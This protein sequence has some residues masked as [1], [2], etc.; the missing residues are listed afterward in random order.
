MRNETHRLMHVYVY[1][2]I[3]RVKRETE[4]A[5]FVVSGKYSTMM[6]RSV[7]A[8]IRAE[9]CIF[10]FNK[11]RADGDATG[12][13]PWVGRDGETGRGDRGSPGG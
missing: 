7:K 9:S 1:I 3:L 8:R 2:Y 5:K 10:H 12:R 11:T 6:G 4:R 13:S